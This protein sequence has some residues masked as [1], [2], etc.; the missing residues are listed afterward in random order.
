MVK[1]EKK[2]N[3]NTVDIVLKL[4]L[5]KLINANTKRAG[6]VNRFFFYRRE[7]IFLNSIFQ[8]KAIRTALFFFEQ[9]FDFLTF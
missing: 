2:N 3:F 8:I 1:I 7:L 9:N 4:K 6:L 5:A